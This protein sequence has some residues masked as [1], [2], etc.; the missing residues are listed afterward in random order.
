MRA[1]LQSEDAHSTFST[2]TRILRPFSTMTGESFHADSRH[3]R[4][5]LL[6]LFHA[7]TRLHRTRCAVRHNF[8]ISVHSAVFLEKSVLPKQDQGASGAKERRFPV[9]PFFSKNTADYVL[10]SKNGADFSRG[11]CLKKKSFKL[12]SILKLYWTAHQGMVLVTLF[13]THTQNFHQSAVL[14]TVYSCSPGR[15]MTTN[16][17]RRTQEPSP[18]FASLILSYSF[19]GRRTRLL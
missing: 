19:V 12:I 10:F 7:T 8:R 3:F 17:G 16:A 18:G 14:M 6:I 2:R 5:F 4:P 9:L 13:T 11:K 1:L 15:G